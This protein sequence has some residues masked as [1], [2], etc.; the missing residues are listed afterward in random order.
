MMK[1]RLSAVLKDVFS[2]PD[3]AHNCLQELPLFIAIRL[4]P[5]HTTRTIKTLPLRYV[6]P[7]GTPAV[8]AAA[9]SAA[10]TGSGGSL[11]RAPSRL[12]ACAISLSQAG[13]APGGW[14]GG[15]GGMLVGALWAAISA[16]SPPA[17]P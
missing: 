10:S 5:R 12:I 2:L 11:T 14:S 8:A 4:T 6:P 13:Q 7:T 3:E 9:S 15:T 17:I 16:A 1:S